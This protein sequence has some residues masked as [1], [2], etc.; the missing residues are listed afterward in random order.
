MENKCLEEC[1]VCGKDP[2]GSRPLLE[3]PVKSEGISHLAH[4]THQLLCSY[5]HLIH[6]NAILP[7]VLA[8]VLG[9][10]CDSSLSLTLKTLGSFFKI[11]PEL[12]CHHPGPSYHCLLPDYR[13][14]LS[15]LSVSVF[16]PPQ[17]VLNAVTKMTLLKCKSDHIQI[18]CSKLVQPLPVSHGGKAKFPSNSP[19]GPT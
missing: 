9:V 18:L 16:E 13:N 14:L 11:Y 8:K 3:A 17:S 6:G 7:V 12:V 5:S 10:I 2:V 19:E 1:P 15:G 4:L